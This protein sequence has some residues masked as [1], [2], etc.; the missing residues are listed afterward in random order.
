MERAMSDIE[1]KAKAYEHLT[2]RLVEAVHGREWISPCVK[3]KVTIKVPMDITSDEIDDMEEIM[4][5]II[6]QLRRWHPA[7]EL[8]FEAGEAKP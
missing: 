6:R 4:R 8:P 2:E 3:G 1:Q 5:L 7:N